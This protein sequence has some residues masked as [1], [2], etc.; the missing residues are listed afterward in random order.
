MFRVNAYYLDPTALVLAET[1]GHDFADDEADHLIPVQGHQ[2]QAAV[3][4]H[5]LASIGGL[6][7]SDLVSGYDFLD[8]KHLLQVFDAQFAYLDRFQGIPLSINRCE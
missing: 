6:F 2:T 4:L 5:M 1:V 8:M 7:G 3:I